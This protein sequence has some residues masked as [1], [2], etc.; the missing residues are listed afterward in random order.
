MSKS[1][2]A[3]WWIRSSSASGMGWMLSATSSCGNSP[4]GRMVCSPTKGLITRINSDLANDLG[5][6][7]SRSVSMIEKYF[8]GTLPEERQADPLDDELIAMVGGLQ[9]KYEEQMEK[10]AFQN[11][12]IPRVF[13]V[14]SR[15]N[16]YVDETAP[17]VL[18][19]DE[20]NK[21]RL[22]T[23]AVQ[24]GGDHPGVRH[25]ADPLYPL[26]PPQDF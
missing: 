12:L 4:L 15:A 26:Y 2:R 3:M 5:N 8:S 21:A 18:G 9:A 6:L 20:A 10:Y 13:K 14:V 17:W 23:R 19:R 22:A 11:A 1:K 24:P 7:V 16:K 25:P